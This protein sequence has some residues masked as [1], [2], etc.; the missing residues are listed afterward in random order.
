MYMISYGDR[1][2]L[3]IALPDLGREFSLSSI[4]MGWVASSFMWSYFILNLPSTMLLDR[5]GARRVGSLAVGLWSVAM[6]LGGITQSLGQFLFTRVLLGAGEAP[7]FGVGATIVRHWAKPSERGLVMTILLTGMQLGLAGGTL[8][9]ATLIFHFGWRFEFV[10]LGAVGLIWVLAWWVLYRDKNNQISASNKKIIT[11]KQIQSLFKA[12]SFWGILIAQCTQNYL[13]FLVLSW[14]PVYLIHELHISVTGAGSHTAT[15]YLIAAVCAIFIGRIAEKIAFLRGAIPKRR[16]FV[17]AFFFLGAASIG[18]LPFYHSVTPILILL[19]I[20]LCCLISA[21]GSNTALLTELIS[22][23]SKI[24]TVTG[25]TLT[26]SNGLGL[27]A[28][29]AT[30]Y[31]VN[32]TGRFDAAWYISAASLIFA[33]ILSTILVKEEIE[34]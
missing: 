25:V 5:Y 7:T 6:M 29:I 13:N 4:Q 11:L 20:S 34:I 18:L 8:A 26:F 12:R 28:P 31:I 24:G 17:V 22:D 19:S 23:G 32:Y 9:G 33:G 30:G 10:A 2:A 27:L 15:C 3:S 1:A 16:R 21:N 14:L